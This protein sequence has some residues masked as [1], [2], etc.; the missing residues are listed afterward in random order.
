MDSFILLNM[1][2][3]FMIALVCIAL[4]RAR[5]S[6]GGAHETCDGD[7]AKCSYFA[8]DAFATAA[9]AGRWHVYTI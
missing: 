6:Q 4:D 7:E 5:N 2:F 8:S 3:L 9:T 1:G